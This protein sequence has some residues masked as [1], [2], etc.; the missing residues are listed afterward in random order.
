VTRSSDLSNSGA[1]LRSA[2]CQLESLLVRLPRCLYDAGMAETSD[3]EE[4]IS[5]REFLDRLKS[6]ELRILHGEQDVTEP[7]IAIL[8]REIAFLNAVLIWFKAGGRVTPGLKSRN[9]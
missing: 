3:A 9:V 2:Q 5:L 4:L 8:K 6:G 1:A 7:Q